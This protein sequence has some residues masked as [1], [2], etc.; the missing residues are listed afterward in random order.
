MI[1]VFRSSCAA[2]PVTRLQ[3][4]LP[5]SSHHS[6]TTLVSR[7]PTLR[8]TTTDIACPQDDSCNQQHRNECR[9]Q[10][11]G[12]PKTAKYLLY[13]SSHGTEVA[14]VPRRRKEQVD[15][16]KQPHRKDEDKQAKGL[17]RPIDTPQFRSKRLALCH[18]ATLAATPSVHKQDQGNHHPPA[19]RPAT[20]SASSPTPPTIDE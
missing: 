20:Y 3:L 8:I 4:T 2:P 19:T 6:F 18:D 13:E 9:G 12:S 17:A 5:A 14:N 11:Y 10:P 16:Y 1:S 7:K 15:S